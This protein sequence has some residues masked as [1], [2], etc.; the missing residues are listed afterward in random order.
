MNTQVLW[1]DDIRDPHLPYFKSMI[2]QEFLDS[3]LT[4]VKSYQEFIDWINERGLPDLI[5]FDHDLGIGKTGYD[6]AKFIVEYA[7]D[8]DTTIPKWII[9]SAN[10][11]GSVNIDSLLKNFNKRNHV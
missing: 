7:L 3:E 8:N 9:Q 11:V 10:P 6:A 2:P 4:W 1:L 5:C